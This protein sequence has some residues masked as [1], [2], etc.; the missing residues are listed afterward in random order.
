MWW[1][2][3]GEVMQDDGSILEVKSTLT[4]EQALNEYSD[5]H[6]GAPKYKEI[7]SNM[8]EKKLKK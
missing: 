6:T 3:E 4:L 2:Y 1:Y 7:Q 8:T 5:R